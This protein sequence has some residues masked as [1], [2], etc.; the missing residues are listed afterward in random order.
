VALK[1]N[2]GVFRD[3]NVLGKFMQMKS[4]FWRATA[5]VVPW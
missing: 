1:C 3:V 5:G 4:K 2:G